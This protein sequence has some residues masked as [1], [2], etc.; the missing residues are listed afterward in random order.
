M[1]V[2]Q[3]VKYTS[4]II[5]EKVSEIMIKG[6]VVTPPFYVGNKFISRSSNDVYRRNGRA[7]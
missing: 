6:G 4:L 7:G 2:D 1:D 5:I 3:K